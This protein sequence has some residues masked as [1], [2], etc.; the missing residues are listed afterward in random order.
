MEK[1]EAEY[2]FIYFQWT[3]AII[4]YTI[5]STFS[6]SERL[7]IAKSMKVHIIFS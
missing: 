5:S 6:E 3:D 1:K 7:V 4:P 2:I